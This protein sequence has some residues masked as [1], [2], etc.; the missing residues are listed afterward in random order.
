MIN[1]IKLYIDSFKGLSNESWMLALVMLINRSGSMVLPFLGIYMSSHLGFGLKETGMVLSCFGFGSV[2]G[3]WFGGMITDKIGEFTVQYISLFL[4]VPMFC[5]IPFFKT[6]ISLAIIIFLQSSISECFRPA[7]SVAVTKYAKKG[8]LTRAFS[9]NRLAMNLGF[10][11][12]P[13]LGGILSTISYDFL[14]YSNALGALLAGITYVWFFRNRKYRNEEEVAEKSESIDISP[15]RDF[16]FILFAFACFLFSVCFFQLL[17]TLTLFYKQEAQLTPQGI[18][19][20]LAYSGFIIVLMEMMLVQIADKKFRLQTTLFLGTF[21][22]GVSFFMLGFG[23]AIWF[24]ILSM[25][26]LCI[27]EIWTLPFMS[28]ATALR[29]GVNN[30][31]AYMG[32][33]GIGFSLS[34]IITPFLGTL[35]AQ[36][37]GFTVL[38]IGTGILM[39]ITAILFYFITPWMLGNKSNETA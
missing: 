24:L 22:C 11:I 34:F 12:G 2:F 18:G 36:Q 37:F 35:I 16:K 3:S 29:S 26:L 15:Y 10:S 1:P 6:E 38:W 21:L 5:L 39:G 14:F 32:L 8:N 25:T 19:Y 17:N 4:S 28:T 20:I 33:L 9:L 23:H 7:N 30:K 31:G 13:A 27:G